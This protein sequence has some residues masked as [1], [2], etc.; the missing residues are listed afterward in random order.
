[1]TFSV[2][3]WR[4]VLASMLFVTLV[5]SVKAEEIPQLEQVDTRVD[6]LM[7]E[8][9]FPGVAIA[10]L[11]DGKPLH[12]GTYGMANLAHQVPVT[13]ETVFELASLTKQ[14]TAL[15]IMTLVEEERLSLDDRL[16]EWIEDAPPAWDKITVDQLLSHTAGLNHH[17]ERTLNDVHL[18][19]YSR[20]DMLASAKNSP[21]VAEPG[22]DWNYSD[23]GYFLLGVIIE[24]VTGQSYANFMQA[25]FFRPLGMDQ[26]HLLDQRKIVPHL[27]QGYAWSDG[28]LQRNRRVWQFALTSHFGVMSSL[29]DM[30]RWEAELSNPELIN[31]A[32]LEATWEIQRPFDTGQQCDTWGYA[33]GWQVAVANGRRILSHGGYS[34]TAYIRDVDTGLSVIVLTNRQDTPNA[35]SPMSLAWEVAHTVDSSIPSDGYRCWE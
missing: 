12:A 8:G 6:S 7:E 10:I 9:H 28:E 18:L 27:A 25:T 2:A 19:E 34:G 35:L 26:T 32:A 11:R 5:D 30:M 13:T 17:F 22:T 24:E 15:A 23:Q 21:M 29:A 14:M 4:F 20:D 16:V 31:R 33:R 1:M 3:I